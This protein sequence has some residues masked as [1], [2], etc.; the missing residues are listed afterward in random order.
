MSLLF[1]ILLVPVLLV[2]LNPVP[3]LVFAYLCLGIERLWGAAILWWG[4]LLP[5]IVF[6]TLFVYSLARAA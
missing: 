2:T 3:V 4:V 6:S 1:T 5:G